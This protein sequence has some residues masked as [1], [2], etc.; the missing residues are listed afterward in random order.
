[1]SPTN[2]LPI[3]RHIAALINSMYKTFLAHNPNF[4]SSGRVSIVGHS[5]GS[6]ICFELLANAGKGDVPTL[7]FEPANYFALGSPI[8]FYL[9][10][11]GFRTP[12]SLT[13]HAFRLRARRFFNIFHP[14]DPVRAITSMATA[15]TI[16][17]TNAATTTAIVTTTMNTTITITAQTFSSPLLCRLHIASSRCVMRILE[18]FRHSRSQAMSL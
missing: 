10:M 14:L 16:A 4:S 1:M 12:I 17:V 8:G 9:G 7:A 3:L 13:D 2:Q 11:Q 18:I 15:I 6:T 5:L